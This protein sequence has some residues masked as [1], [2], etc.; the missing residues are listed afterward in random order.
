MTLP[1]ANFVIMVVYSFTEGRGNNL[2]EIGDD[3]LYYF[4]KIFS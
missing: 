4:Y 3:V 1:V 2:Y